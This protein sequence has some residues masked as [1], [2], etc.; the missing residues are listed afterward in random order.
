ML[1]MNTA[2]G[3]VVETS[4]QCA[5]TCL[6]SLPHGCRGLSVLL[7]SE[8]AL[9]RELALCDPFRHTEIPEEGEEVKCEPESDGPL[10]YR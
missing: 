2:A 7:H 4:R 5:S 6:I 8:E 9:T 3:R 1:S 10:H